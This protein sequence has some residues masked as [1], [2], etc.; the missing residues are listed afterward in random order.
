[1]N[2]WGSLEELAASEHFQEFLHREFPDQASEWEDEPS[3]RK[4]FKLM[5]ASLALAGVT[6]CTRQPTE[7]IVPY[8]R[9]PEEIVPG[10]PLFY[11]TAVSIGG[12]GQGVLVKCNEGRPIKVE[13]NPDHPA[14][15]GATDVLSQA[16]VLSLYDP[17][18]AQNITFV[19]EVRTWGSFSIA[20]RK[21]LDAQRGKGG[22]GLRILSETVV[23]PTLGAQMNELLRQFP[24]AKWHQYEPAGPHSARSGA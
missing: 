7:T 1:M 15:L 11:A 14:S 10:K 6:A 9:A 13:G 18:R 20:I 21:A 19:N 24:A 8:V 5:G 3:R 23:S 16:S 12:V 2:H 4:F 17:D 22:A